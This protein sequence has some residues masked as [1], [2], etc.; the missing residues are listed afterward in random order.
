MFFKPDSSKNA[1]CNLYLFN[2]EFVNIVRTQ[3]HS[4]C[5]RIG[6]STL[7]FC[8]KGSNIVLVAQKRQLN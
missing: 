3:S 4:Q 6:Y 8:V 1:L 5:T 7:T 2:R